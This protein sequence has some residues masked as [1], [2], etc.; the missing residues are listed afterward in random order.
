MPNP[1]TTETVKRELSDLRLAFGVLREPF[2]WL[3][4]AYCMPGSLGAVL[5]K[6]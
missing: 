2:A 5:A 3:V 6:D 1:P 4:Q